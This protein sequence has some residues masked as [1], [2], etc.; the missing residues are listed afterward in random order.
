MNFAFET[1]KQAMVEPPVLAFLDFESSFVAETGASTVALGAVLVQK[2]EDGEFHPI[3]F[4]VE[5]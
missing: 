4:L 1:L 3:N 2:K 5:I